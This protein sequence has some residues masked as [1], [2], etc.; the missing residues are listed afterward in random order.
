MGG[1]SQWFG[2]K[3]IAGNKEINQQLQDLFQTIPPQ[4]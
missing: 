3:V 2:G 4:P 1:N